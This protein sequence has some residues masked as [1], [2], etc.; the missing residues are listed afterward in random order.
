MWATGI[1][2][3]D[4]HYNIS[5][6]DSYNKKWNFAWSP[7]ELGKTTAIDVQKI[8]K[9][10]HE[11]GWPTLI[12][13]NQAADM[14]DAQ[15][16]SIENTINK[17]KGREVHLRAKKDTS[18]IWL[19]YDQINSK[20][21]KLF[22]IMASVSAPIRRLKG[23]NVGQI[24]CIVYDEFMV[25]TLMGE[26]YPEGLA[27]KIK[28]IYKTFVRECRPRLLKIYCFGNP[29]SRYHP[30]FVDLGVNINEIKKGKILS[31]KNYVI[32][33]A[34]LSPEL[35]QFILENDPG[36]EFDD[37][38]EKYAFEGDAINDAEI[39]LVEEQPEGFKL[40]TVFKVDNRYLWVFKGTLAI[41]DVLRY[42]RYWMKVTA[43]QPGKRQDIICV[44]FASLTKNGRLVKLFKGYFESLADNIA[45][46]QVGYQS[47][48]AFYL[49]QLI[50]PSL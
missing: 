9:G 46:N 18:T 29:Y 27:F 32:D 16:L 15:V 22:A 39:N 25:N 33:A 44:D 3:D 35:R 10:Y 45:A 19:I 50:F 17:F 48:E 6:L 34:V 24:N 43:V 30:L 28:E 47:P 38:Y 37:P 1:N 21:E 11:N 36:H 26:K 14:T 8:F 13:F 40:K 49:A 41:T 42:P 4:I 12:L 5:R 2:F 23:L 20:Q 31:G 7:R